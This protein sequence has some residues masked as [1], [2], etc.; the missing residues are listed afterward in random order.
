VK[1]HFT[2]DAKFDTMPHFHVDKT[3]YIYVERGTIRLTKNGVS[4][5]VDASTGEIE[6][7]K[8]APHRWEVLGGEE[9]V[10]LERTVPPDGHKEAF[11]RNFMSLINDYGDMPPAL[12]AFKIFADWDNYPIG[13]ASWM[14]HT[15]TPIV[16]L[17]KAVGWVAGI[18]GYRSMYREYTPRELYEKLQ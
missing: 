5:M 10:V 11:F 6:I 18:V 17:T 2:K 4:S 14:G 3:E 8:W 15:R 12:Q 9:T 13:E 7:P 1:F 16:G